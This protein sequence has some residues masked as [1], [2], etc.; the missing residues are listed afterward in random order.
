MIV[1]IQLLIK[2]VFFNKFNVTLSL[3]NFHFSLLV[4]STV[5]IALGGYIINDLNDIKADKINKPPK[6]FVGRLLTKQKA[7]YLFLIFNFIGLLL[8]YYI[9][10][11]IDKISFFAIYIIASLLSYLYSIK[12]K[13]MLLIKNLIVSF[14]VF[15]SIFIV[16]LYDIVPATN[17]YNNQGQLEVFNLLF[18][19]SIFAFLLTLLREMIKDIEDIEGDKKAGIKSLPIVFSINKTKIIIYAI[20][21]LTLV[22]IDYFAI[23]LYIFN[24]IASLYL[25]IVVSLPLI[26][27]M[28][29]LYMSKSKR[30]F[31]KLSKLLKLFMF[32]VMLTIFF[33]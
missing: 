30:E 17:A 16:A 33:L 29:K 11:S 12:L 13:K 24:A 14:L 6:V 4:I 21:I 3:D 28:V 27:F 10:Y 1:L 20:T 5:L 32:L 8:G 19:I 22:S 25:L 26:Y 2:Y 15:L 9:S 7:D 31:N 18:K 23:N